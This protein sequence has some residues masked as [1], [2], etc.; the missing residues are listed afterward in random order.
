MRGAEWRRSMCVCVCE[1]RSRGM[2]RCYA[3]V[4]AVL[5]INITLQ[6]PCLPRV[7]DKRFPTPLLTD[8]TNITQLPIAEF[9]SVRLRDLKTLFPA[10]SPCRHTYT[11]YVHILC[12][13]A[14]GRISIPWKMQ[15]SRA[16]NNFSFFF[17]VPS[18]TMIN[19][20]HMQ[21]VK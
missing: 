16:R 10:P 9:P 13:R 3:N 20:L 6:L 1:S 21:V 11:T 19:K 12:S 15:P 2:G 17:S 5:F 18:N 7:L 14:S 8:T 4:C